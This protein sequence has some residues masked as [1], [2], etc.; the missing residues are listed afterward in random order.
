[1]ATAQLS[2]ILKVGIGSP[3]ARVAAANVAGGST[4][5]TNY[6]PPANGVPVQMLIMIQVNGPGSVSV[7]IDGLTFT[8]VSST[9]YLTPISYYLASGQATSIAITC[10][11][12]TTAVALIS[13]RKVD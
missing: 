1:M 13:A 4:N 5:T 3:T 8:A 10:P 12:G 11:S 9:S 7:V 6:T 2:S